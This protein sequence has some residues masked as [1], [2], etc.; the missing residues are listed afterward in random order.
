MR[1]HTDVA[2]YVQ[3]SP[4]TTHVEYTDCMGFPVEQWLGC[5]NPDGEVAS[6]NPADIDVL[7]TL[8]VTH[9]LTL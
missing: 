2:V 9:N 1:M 6:S 3:D 8:W 5:G 4:Y 7:Y